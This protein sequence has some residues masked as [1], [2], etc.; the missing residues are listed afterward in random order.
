[1]KSRAEGQQKLEL[2][3]E[4]PVLA[5][6]LDL[7]NH[8]Q[9]PHLVVDVSGF[10]YHR[11]HESLPSHDMC[12]CLCLCLSPKLFQADIHNEGVEMDLGSERC[13]AL[14]YIPSG[15]NVCPIP[16]TFWFAFASISG[17]KIDLKY[18]YFD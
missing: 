17:C 2:P 3:V 18:Q 11:T 1:M 8:H 6:V 10:Y 12:L 7:F 16:R 9:N 14:T 13:A 5:P 15:S 4:E